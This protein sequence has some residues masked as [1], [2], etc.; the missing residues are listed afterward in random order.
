MV[1]VVGDRVELLTPPYGHGHAVGGD[2]GA[3]TSTRPKSLINRTTV[4]GPS[5][6]NL[7]IDFCVNKIWINRC[8]LRCHEPPSCEIRVSPIQIAVSAE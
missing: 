7:A 8:D 5:G 1:D 3:Y 4:D 6:P 2:S